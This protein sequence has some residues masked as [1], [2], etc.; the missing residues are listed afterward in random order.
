MTIYAKE[1]QRR[2]NSGEPYNTTAQWYIHLKEPWEM[3]FRDLEPIEQAF[4][5][6]LYKQFRAHLEKIPPPESK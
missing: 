2:L 5:K 6:Q 3:Y 1:L 4:V